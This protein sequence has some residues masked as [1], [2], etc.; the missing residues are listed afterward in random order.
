MQAQ[1][2]KELKAMLYRDLEAYKRYTMSSNFDS[3]FQFMP[4][5]MFE[6]T[7]LDSLLAATRHAFENEKMSLEIKGMD[8]KSKG[9]MKIKKAK[10][11]HWVFVPYDMTMRIGLKGDS[12]FKTLF[13]K[14]LKSEYGS[15][16]IQEEGESALLLTEKNKRM[17]AYKDPASPIWFFLEDK[18]GKASDQETELLFYHV[19]P[20]EVQEAVGKQ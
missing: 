8:Y 19:I 17:I 15:E 20:I 18:R 14:M 16:N 1:S 3:S 13:T 7:P 9:K 4:P 2:K 5:K 11:Y 6:I 10:I 12:A